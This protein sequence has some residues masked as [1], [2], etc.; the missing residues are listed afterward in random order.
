MRKFDAKGIVRGV[1][2][3]ITKENEELAR[4]RAE[5]CAG[6]K[7]NELETNSFFKVSDKDERI[8]NRRCGKCK[9]SLHFLI[10]D[11]EAKCEFWNE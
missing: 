11:K 1:K 10:R 4:R 2:A 7:F 9:C 6:C 5:V 3:S 8:S